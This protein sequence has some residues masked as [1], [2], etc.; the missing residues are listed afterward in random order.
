MKPAA[1]VR[2]PAIAAL[3]TVSALAQVGQF[4]IGFMVLPVWLA[5]RGLDAPRAGLFSAAQWTGMLAGLLIAPWLMVRIGAKRTVSLGLA[6][7]LVAFATM[8]ALSWPSWLVPGL[9]TGLGIGLRWIANE[10]WLY[11]LVPAQSS[12]RV[13]GVHEA[14]IATAG[15]IGP[16]LAA[17]CAVDGRIT[18]MAGAAFTF[19]AALPLW[20]TAPDKTRPAVETAVPA[21]RDSHRQRVPIGPLVSLGMVVIAAGGIGDG[22]LYGLFPLFADAHGLSATQTATMLTLFGVGGMALQF[23]VGWLADRA[24]LAATVIVCAALSTLAICGFALAAPASWLAAAS[25]LLLGGMNSSYITLGMYAAACSEKSALTRNMRLLSLTFTASSIVGPLAAGFAMQA[26][27]AD[28]LMWQLALA[29]GA[30]AAY[31]L[32]LREGRRQPERSSSMG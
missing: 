6:A 22:A 31:A 26:R 28:M 13:V 29:S 5:H 15:V 14:L 4:G 30:L 20:L 12:G 17:W 8:S 2:W 3:T 1:P 18:F 10:T 24:G 11:S 7:T 23:P 32:G 9:L 16:A 27:G 21:R 19:A 25:A